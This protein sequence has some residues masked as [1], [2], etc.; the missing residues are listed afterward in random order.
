MVTRTQTE[1]E[2]IQRFSGKD[3]DTVLREIP[4]DQ[5]K[6]KC[7]TCMTILK[8]SELIDKKCPVCGENHLQ[9]MCPVDHNSCSH[10]IIERIEYC[11]VCKQA[12]CPECGDHS[13]VQISRVTGYLQDVSGWNNSKKAE[14][15][16]RIRSN[17]SSDGE[18]I[19]V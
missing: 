13:V 4:E 17:L 3:Y 18:M 19:R 12:I 5:R 16:D 6:W 15:K 1:L 10:T 2:I 7:F 9:Q 8:N 11:P 14:L